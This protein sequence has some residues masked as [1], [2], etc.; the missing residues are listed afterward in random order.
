MFKKL[1]LGNITILSM[2]FIPTVYASELSSVEKIIALNPSI[3]EI[4][5]DLIEHKFTCKEL[6]NGYVN[7][8]KLYNLSVET[9]R[10]PLNAVTYINPNIYVDADQLDKK[11]ST[12]K[13]S[14]PQLFC[15]PVIVKDTV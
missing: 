13:T 5:Q 9:N 10:A 1:L 7:R 11:L 4:H 2:L 8:I 6:I 3:T 14:L 12:E 15:V